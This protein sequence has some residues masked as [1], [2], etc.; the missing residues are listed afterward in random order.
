MKFVEMTPGHWIRRSR[1][2]EVR[3]IDE[4]VVEFGQRP[5]VQVKFKSRGPSVWHTFEF[6]T[7]EEAI[8]HAAQLLNESYQVVLRLGNEELER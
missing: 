8:D 3:I 6:A 1:V 7:A 5:A 2:E 4:P